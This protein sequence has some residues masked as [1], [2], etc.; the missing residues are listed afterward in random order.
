MTRLDLA[1]IGLLL[2]II[3]VAGALIERGVWPLILEAMR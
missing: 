2:T 1:A 3:C